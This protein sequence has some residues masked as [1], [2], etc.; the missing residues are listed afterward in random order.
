MHSLTRSSSVTSAVCPDGVNQR[1]EWMDRERAWDEV[2]HP[3]RPR[4]EADPLVRLMNARLGVLNHCL[5]LL[6]ERG[7]VPRVC[8]YALTVRGQE[9][10]RSPSAARDF[11]LRQDWQVGGSNQRI[12]DRF[13]TTDPLLR[14]G[15]SLVRFQIRAGY[16]DGVVVLT[17]SVISPHIDEYEPQL[18]LIERHLGFVA[19][20]T[21][22]TA[23]Q[24]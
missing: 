11:A 4:I 17:H 6:Q 23:R 12:T 21:P 3:D 9:P 2:L 18:D 22:E 20:L 24:R 10:T 1:Q 7:R 5:A 15:W 19:L 16:A 8:L 14:P 13:G